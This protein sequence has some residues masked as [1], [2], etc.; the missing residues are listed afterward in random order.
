MRGRAREKPCTLH[1]TPSTLNPYP[2]TLNPQP[3]TLN[4]QPHTLNPKP[5]TSNAEAYTR[6]DEALALERQMRLSLRSLPTD[7]QVATLE[8]DSL[9]A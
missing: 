1:P 3:S 5:L 4:P 2:S 7:H 8:S 9:E 6:W